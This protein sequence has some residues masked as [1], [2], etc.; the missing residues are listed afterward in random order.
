MRRP[1]L[2]RAYRNA[3]LNWSVPAAMRSH[4]AILAE[5]VATHHVRRCWREA[6]L[7]RPVRPFG[8]RFRGPRDSARPHGASARASRAWDRPRALVRRRSE[9]PLRRSPC[10]R[11]QRSKLFQE[12]N[13]RQDLQI[14][15]S[16]TDTRPLRSCRGSRGSAKAG[17]GSG[18]ISVHPSSRQKNSATSS[19]PRRSFE[20][21]SSL[22]RR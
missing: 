20:R 11:P 17:G 22:S 8:G 12:L 9:S 7:P 19:S 6:G 21:T 13:T 3:P 5:I 18:S 16:S 15:V 14:R 2:P 1:R 10:L 4:C